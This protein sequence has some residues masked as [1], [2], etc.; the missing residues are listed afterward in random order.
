MVQASGPSACVCGSPWA[1]V[2]EVQRLVFEEAAELGAG[3]FA[4]LE[5]LLA[6]GEE[7]RRRLRESSDWDALWEVALERWA[8]VQGLWLRELQGCARLALKV[9]E[10]WLR[11]WVLPLWGSEEAPAA[12]ASP[13]QTAANDPGCGSA[14][15]QTAPEPNAGKEPDRSSAAKP[16]SARGAP[17]ASA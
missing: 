11:S 13:Q 9:Q 4:A 14:R 3:R 16:R 8:G 10:L 1:T 17:A 5:A 12:G 2:W 6:L 7:E 15:G